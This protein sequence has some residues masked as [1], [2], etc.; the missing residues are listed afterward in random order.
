MDVIDVFSCF[1][2]ATLLAFL[3]VFIVSTF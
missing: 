3:N 2:P 1:I